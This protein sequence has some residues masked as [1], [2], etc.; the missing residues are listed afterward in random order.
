LYEVKQA[1]Q[2]VGFD[3]VDVGKGLVS[4]CNKFSFVDL[5][6]FELHWSLTVNGRL[7]HSGVVGD[8]S[9]IQAGDCQ[10]LQILWQ[11]PDLNQAEEVYLDLQIKG[12][13]MSAV[14]AIGHLMAKAQFKLNEGFACYK[15]KK[16]TGRL[17]TTVIADTLS[18]QVGESCIRFNQ[19]SGELFSWKQSSKELIKKGFVPNFWRGMTDND[20]GNFLLLRAGNWKR[21]SQKDKASSV[22]IIHQNQDSVQLEVVYQLGLNGRFS[23]V[24]TV[25]EDARMKVAVVLKRGALGRSELPRVGLKI[26]LPPSYKQLKWFGRGPFENYQDRKDAAH[27]AQY[28]ST[29]LQQY[30]PYIRPQENGYKTDVRWLQLTDAS[31]AGFLFQGK[32]QFFCFSALPYLDEDFQA[33]VRAL[34]WANAQNQHYS[35][36]KARPITALNIDLMQQGLGGDDSWWTKPHKPYRLNE[37]VYSYQFWMQAIQL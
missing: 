25:Y 7:F 19:Q 21:A 35:A 18:I 23:I 6:S 1:Y 22:R 27:V 24:Y 9:A 14:S 36:L 5:S 8:L 20:Y 31:G 13:R 17:S 30:V 32:Q 34:G 15:A 3:T 26:Q 4:V 37:R 10:V 28:Q 33:S 11:L 12:K 29:V 16:L 2:Y